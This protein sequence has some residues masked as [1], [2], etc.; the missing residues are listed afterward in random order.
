MLKIMIRGK[1][2]VRLVIRKNSYLGTVI[3]TFKKRFKNI[4]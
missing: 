2:N 3:H 4:K 1:F